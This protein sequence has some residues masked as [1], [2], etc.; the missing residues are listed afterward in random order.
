MPDF[1]SDCGEQRLAV[2][3]LQEWESL[4]YGMFLHFGISTFLG[5]ELP[6][7]REP[8]SAYAPDKLDVDQW[9]SVARDAGMKYAVLT[10]KHV[11]GHC[12]W[13]SKL[14]DYHVGTSGTR[15]DVMEDFVKACD[16]R[17]VLPGIYYCSWDNHHT[18]GSLVPG[19]VNYWPADQ[20]IEGYF[21]WTR[22][23]TTPEYE[24][25]Q[26]GQL[27]ELLH[28]YGKIAEV[29]IDIPCVLTRYYRQKLYHQIAGWQPQTVVMMNNGMSD[30]AKY[31]VEYSWPADIMALER[32][33]PPSGAGHEKWR[34]IE[35]KRHYIPGEVCDTIGKEWFYKENDDPRSDREL[36]GMYLLSRS[37]G[38]NFLLNVPP[39]EHGQIPAKYRESLFRL[40]KTLE[41]L[42]MAS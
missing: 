42:G 19:V 36:L 10:A 3:K 26:M 30:G 2:E 8:S 6:S 23:Y 41:D 40:R 13:P 7:G 11:A 16:K 9:V 39:D 33:V 28:N 14:T 34:T 31:P 38:A 18:F 25:F 32:H 37:R 35:M 12:L 21:G 4:G 22:Y 24:D 1:Q 29:W 27:E 20:R 5:E 17:G 15:T